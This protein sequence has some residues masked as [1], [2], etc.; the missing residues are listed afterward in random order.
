MVSLGRCRGRRH[1]D[2][3]S[4]S[5]PV[6]DGGRKEGV[7]GV[8][9]RVAEVIGEDTRDGDDLEDEDEVTPGSKGRWVEGQPLS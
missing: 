8:A 5:A 6:G 4:P 7:R 1:A 3:G 2:A 9:D